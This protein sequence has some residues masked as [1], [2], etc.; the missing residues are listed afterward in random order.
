MSKPLDDDDDDVI[1]GLYE[2]GHWAWDEKVN[3][4]VFKSDLP[5]EP[6]DA[7][8][9]ATAILGSVEFREDI[10]LNEQNRFRKRMQR[11]AEPD[12]VV[13]LQDVK[14]VVLFTAPIKILKPYLINLLHLPATER[15]L[16]ALIFYCQYHLQTSDTMNNRTIEL[17]TKIRTERSVEVEMHYMDNLEDLRLLVAKEYSNLINGSG[18]FAKFHHMGPSKKMRSM[19]RKESFLFETF[20]RMSIQIIWIALGRKSFDEIELEVHRM[21]KSDLFNSAEH[22]LTGDKKIVPRTPHERQVLIGHCIVKKYKVDMMSPLIN[23]V[24]CSKRNIDHR[25]FGLG[26]VQYPRSSS[27]STKSATSRKKST[28]GQAPMYSS[29][30]LP[31]RGSDEYDELPSEFPTESYPRKPCDDK[32]RRKWLRRYQRIVNKHRAHSSR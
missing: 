31:P 8:Q 30:E 17:M 22:K 16:R 1:G 12:D 26:I 28:L 10:D 14:D 2:N 6:P 25:M 11:K 21:F 29:I 18:E 3:A 13:T 27:R 23:E 19:N 15:I 32:Q 7:P 9:L 5:E 24:H 4:L 20:V